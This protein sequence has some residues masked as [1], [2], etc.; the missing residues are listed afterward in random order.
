[1]SNEVVGILRAIL[2]ADTAEFN[3]AL[4]RSGD[5]VKT[6]SKAVGSIGQELS[7]G[8]GESVAKLTAAFSISH[9]VDKGVS[10]LVEFGKSAF[11][12]AGHV[13]D[14]S[15]KLGISTD[16]IQRY[17]FVAE[18]SGTTVE[19]FG[20]AIFKL[21]TNVATGGKA[22]ED[23]LGA[24]G[25]SMANL[26]SL[27]PEDQFD[28]VARALGGLSD[29][30]ERNRIGVALMGKGYADIAA[31]MGTYAQ[32]V[33]EANVVDAERIRA[34]DETSKAYD[35]LTT[36]IESKYTSAVGAVVLG[37][38]KLNKA[39]VSYLELLLNMGP[40]TLAHAVALS[41]EA[42]A[43]EVMNALTAS[44]A[45][46]PP[47]VP[48]VGEGWAINREITAIKP[49]LSEAA[50][51]AEAFAEAV[52]KVGI[53]ISQGGVSDA[54]RQMSAELK[55]AE[56]NGGLT[57]ASL[58]KYGKQIDEWIAQ[59]RSVDA[60][61]SKT[62]YD[63]VLLNASLGMN[64]D[65][66]DAIVT[67]SPNLVGAL[68]AEGAAARQAAIDTKTLADNRAYFESLAAKGGSKLMGEI[69]GV[70]VV[71][72]GI[73]VAPP[74]AW[75]ASLAT[76]L[77]SQIPATMTRAFEGGGSVAKS[78]GST[79]GNTVASSVSGSFAKSVAPKIGAMFGSGAGLATS[80][81]AGVGTM[82]I[83]IGIQA[84]IAGAT[85][86]VKHHQN[87]TVKDRQ[88]FASQMGF[89]DLGAL[90]TDLTKVNAEGAK[91]ADIGQHVIGKQDTQAN[92]KWMKDVQ[93]F[94]ADVAAKQKELAEDFGK[95]GTAL[96]VFGGSAPKAIRPMI[97]EL[98]KAPG[99]TE[100][101][102]KALQG[103]EDDPSWQ[104]MQDHAEK[105]G[106]SLSALGPAFQ[107]AKITDTAQGYARDIQM[108]ADAGADV[109]EVL[110][111]M[112]DE[113]STLYQD[114]KKNGVALP[115][116][117]K[118]YMEQ[119][120]RM[121]LL[122][123]DS[124]KA[125]EDL[126]DV[127]FKD[128]PDTALKDVV[129]VL[130]EIKDL[131]A[132]GIPAAADTGAAGVADAFANHPVTIP[133]HYGDPGAPPTPFGR[134]SGAPVPTP[135]PQIGL[136]GGTHGAFV[137]WG[138]GTPVTL[139]G[140]EAVVPAGEAVGGLGG[141]PIEITVISQLDGRQVAR[142]QVRYIPRELT[143]AGV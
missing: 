72:G 21:G 5:A 70:G 94:Y 54:M 114:A 32:K 8:L 1:V 108:F 91:L 38:E 113:L 6:W 102:K 143:L 59:G 18:Q 4:K 16:A 96:D 134:T 111:G 12:T 78:I 85:A 23:A 53:A 73:G 34:L 48:T 136:Q 3:D 56:V 142:N 60:E 123:D 139:H 83:S 27:K 57:T 103:M 122:V 40:A 106:I 29:V 19:A 99:L 61:L 120:V 132:K 66:M 13:V 47:K 81:A 15:D 51:A 46:A 65:A 63:W 2:T 82:G 87:A 115:D 68:E 24:L 133:L 129:D 137:D 95:L 41:K 52:K 17:G 37:Y 42:Q 97:D 86:L 58:Q 125:V 9:L 75:G 30:Q 79:V 67:A 80:I 49:Q 92:E 105:L 76:S 88:D 117:L 36:S 62:H 39:G 28:R 10:S 35:R 69:G 101:M 25:L 121:G 7:G 50:K 109:P 130:K 131:L 74:Q 138:A 135:P 31:S 71:P 141:A 20:T 110:R 26:R 14:L 11:T 104:T 90:Y 112:S 84:G 128:I 77:A 22:T 119:L 107:S 45:K 100:D 126:G 140:R 127:A 64:R 44:L 93:A 55:V 124:G 43:Q 116:T 89:G 98:M 33:G 118:P